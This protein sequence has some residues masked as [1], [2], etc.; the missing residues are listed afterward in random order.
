MF[1]VMEPDEVTTVAANLRGEAMPA[2]LTTTLDDLL[3]ALQ[4][5]VDPNNDALVVG[6]MGYLLRSGRLTVSGR[7]GRRMTL[8]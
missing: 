6:T 4:G 5:E 3:A 7:Y 1:T 8:C 2:R